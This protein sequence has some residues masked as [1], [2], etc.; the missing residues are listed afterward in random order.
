[1]LIT[2]KFSVWSVGNPTVTQAVLITEK[3]EFNSPIVFTGKLKIKV[4]NLDFRD[5]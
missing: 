4:K 3:Q 1:M 5:Y 2:S